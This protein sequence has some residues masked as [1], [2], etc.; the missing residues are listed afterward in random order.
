MN[1]LPAQ[2]F[3]EVEYNTLISII[4]PVFNNED[5]IG[6]CLTHVVAYGLGAEII[7]VDGGSEDST[8]AIAQEYPVRIFGCRNGRSAQMNYGASKATRDILYF[9]DPETTPP[10]TFVE[11]IYSSLLQG[12]LGGCFKLRFVDGPWL[13]ELNWYMAR[14]KI[15]CSGGGD[16][17]LFLFAHTFEELGGYDESLEIMLDFDL[18]DRLR[19]SGKFDVITNEIHV[20]SQKYRSISYL[21]VQL[22]NVF[23]YQMFRLGYSQEVLKSTWSRML[24]RP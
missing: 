12:N 24:D 7:I 15:R 2:I 11:D 3:L 17:S 21:K 14:F 9:L 18:V 8:V 23:V 5:C 4:I 6:D 22:A 19:K 13:T 10:V 1:T 20:R 16:Q